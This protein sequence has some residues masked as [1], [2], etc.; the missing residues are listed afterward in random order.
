[1][2]GEHIVG[3]FIPL[4]SSVLKRTTAAK[5]WFGH[6]WRDIRTISDAHITLQF[7]KFPK[8]KKGFDLFVDDLRAHHLVAPTVIFAG[9]KTHKNNIDG[10]QFF[11]L[12]IKKTEDL[13]AL[14]K[15]VLAIAKPYQKGLI[16]KK[17]ILRLKENRFSKREIGYVKRYGYARVLQNFEPHISFGQV[18]SASIKEQR[19]MVNTLKQKLGDTQK[20]RFVPPYLIVGLYGYDKGN[21]TGII[22]E[23]RVRLRH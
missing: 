12:D 23:V 4:P 21:Y 8:T 18:P 1:M 9:A 11:F 7:A 14:H 6:K 2:K 13:Y 15:K 22:H 17:D 3:V 19:R 5:R 20:S 10:G 16:R